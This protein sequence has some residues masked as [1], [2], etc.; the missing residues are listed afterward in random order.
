MKNSAQEAPT[1]TK[2]ESKKMG[3]NRKHCKA[4]SLE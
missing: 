2:G 1:I 3:E 4:R